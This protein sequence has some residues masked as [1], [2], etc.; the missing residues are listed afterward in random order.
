MHCI[1]VRLAETL[2]N[3][4]DGHFEKDEIR[5][6][7]EVFLGAAFQVLIIIMMA[8]LLGIGKEVF[9]I[10]LAAALL[11]GY[12]G[13]GHCQAYYRCTLCSIFIFITL[14]F[15]AQYVQ[16]VYFPIG[17]SFVM[18]LALAIIVK[19]APVDNPINPITDKNKRQRLKKQSVLVTLMLLLLAA[20]AE[21]FNY[22]AIAVSI[23]L[24]IIWQVFTLTKWGHMFSNTWDHAFMFI[25]NIFQRKEG[26]NNEQI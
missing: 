14:G 15:L 21:Y 12:S 20:V 3:H 16:P 13:G 5:Y 10:M 11:R 4:S 25:E 9:T 19:K 7:L 23:L 22:P 24:G 26:C 8:F 17:F 2:A 6:G 1:A 18:I